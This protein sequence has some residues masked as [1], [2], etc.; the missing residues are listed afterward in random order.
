VLQADRLSRRFG[1][2]VVADELSQ[3]RP[4]PGHHRAQWAGKTSVF[5]MLA[6]V[7]RVQSGRILLNGA[8]VTGKAQHERTRLGIGRTYQVP[9]PSTS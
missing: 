5:N 2:I 7:I 3:R 4:V 1:Q 8:D 9:Q 6:G